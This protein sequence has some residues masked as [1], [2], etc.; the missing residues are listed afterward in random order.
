VTDRLSDVEI[1]V[2]SLLE[3]APCGFVSFTDDGTIRVTNA[4]L[5]DMLGYTRDELA[6]I[7][8]ESLFNVGTRIF[9]QTHFF[10]LLKLHGRADEIFLLLRAKSGEDIGVLCN[11]VRRERGGE[12]I[13]DCVLMRVTERQKFED[14]L[15]RAKKEAEEANEQ[16]E[17]QA[18]ELEMS[19]QQL[20]EQAEERARLRHCV[21]TARCT[22]LKVVTL[23]M[24]E[25]VAGERVASAL[26]LSPEN[27][28]VLLHRA[29]AALRGCMTEPLR[30]SAD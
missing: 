3:T 6:G 17:R 24:L 26:G 10:P 7:R 28:A 21:T 18:L 12:W 11:A 4:M 5:R 30:G 9:Y 20:L 1:G 22:S 14:A 13:S 23:R 29:K 8:V 27:V 15:L 25:E 2:D 19:Q 16:L